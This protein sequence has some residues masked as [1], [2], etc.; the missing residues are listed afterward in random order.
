[1]QALAGKDD[2]RGQ[3]IQMLNLGRHR[4]PFEG[5]LLDCVTWLHQILQAAG[6]P[7]FAFCF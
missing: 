2:A 6:W 4:V 5:D 7:G 3:S 1:M